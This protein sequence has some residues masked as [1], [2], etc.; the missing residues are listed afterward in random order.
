MDAVKK[1]PR[2]PQTCT[3]FLFTHR[4][5]NIKLCDILQIHWD[6]EILS[7]SWIC[8]NTLS[9]TTHTDN[10]T[11]SG[12][13][14]LAHHLKLQWVIIATSRIVFFCVALWLEQ[15]VKTLTV[16]LRKWMPG[17]S[18]LNYAKI[19]QPAS[20]QNILLCEHKKYHQKIWMK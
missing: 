16:R 13:N 2:V 11:T 17:A 9:I 15:T 1:H 12:K 10:V 14:M 20:F 6:I 5:E 3:H 4:D 7:V 19:F 8:K 18:E